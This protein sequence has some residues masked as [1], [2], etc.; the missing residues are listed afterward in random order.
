MTVSR[1]TIQ[2]VEFD[3]KISCCFIANK[4]S[5]REDKLTRCVAIE[6]MRA[7]SVK[8]VAMVVSTLNLSCQTK[9]S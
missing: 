8:R 1:A 2:R 6:A 4:L 3:S 5:G 7:G 9:W